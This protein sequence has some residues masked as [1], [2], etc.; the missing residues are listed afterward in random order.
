[1]RKIILFCLFFV[2]I[3][4]VHAEN[5]FHYLVFETT[6]G[7]RFSVP[8]S[9]ISFSIKDNVLTVGEYE[10]VISNLIKM[11]FSAVHESTTSVDDVTDATLGVATEIY[12]MEGKKVQK[13][14]LGKGVY[15]VK[16]K[17]GLNKIVVR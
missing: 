2:G 7:A 8:V 13:K 11:Y 16:M 4:T 6:D 10:F 1:M 9:S 17:N 14:E 3:L 12:N 15:I 5:T